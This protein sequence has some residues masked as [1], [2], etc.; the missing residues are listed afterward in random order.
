VEDAQ[1]VTEDKVKELADAKRK[2]SVSDEGSATPIQASEDG[3]NA[4][5]AA[6]KDSEVT[7]ELTDTSSG[8]QAE[9]TTVTAVIKEVINSGTGTD[10]KDVSVGADD[11]TVKADVIAGLSKEKLDKLLIAQG[12]PVAI[13]DGTKVDSSKITVKETTIPK[14]E[15]DRKSGV[16]TVTF[17]YDGVDVT[18]DVYVEE[19]DKNPPMVTAHDIIISV[20]EIKEAVKNGT[21][22]GQLVERADAR[23]TAKKGDAGSAEGVDLSNA[24]LEKVSAMTTPGVVSITFGNTAGYDNEDAYQTVKVTVVN[25]YRNQDLTQSDDTKD[26]DLVE[27]GANDFCISLKQATAVTKTPNQTDV[28]DMLKELANTTAVKS[29]Y[30]VATRGISVDTSNIK[31]EKGEYEITFT[32]KGAS[33]TRTVTVK[34]DGVTDSSDSTVLVPGTNLTANNFEVKANSDEINA[35]DFIKLASV[36]AN[37]NT[38]EP[39]TDITVDEISLKTLNSTV[40]AGE[41]KDTKV[42]VKV[43]ANGE[44][45]MVTVTVKGTGLT[46]T[47]KDADTEKD[48]G[49]NTETTDTEEPGVVSKKDIQDALGV[50]AETAAKIQ[51]VA[52][53]YN[54][55]L[56]TLKI[57][58][59]SIAAQT[60][61]KDMKG[62]SFGRLKAR[63]IKCKNKQF[64]L[65]WTKTTGADGYMIYGNRCNS[66]GKKYK[67]KYIKTVSKKTTSMK[68]KKLKKGTYYKYFVRAYKLI[69]GKKVTIATSVTVHAT[70]TGGKGGVAKAVKIKKIG[71]KKINSSKSVKYTLKKGKKAKISAAEVKQTTKKIYHHRNICYESSDKSVATVDKKGKITAKGKGKCKIW[72]YAQNG[73]YTT[74]NL[75]VK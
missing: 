55:S 32:Y 50:S 21:L 63:A 70:T 24:D 74:I 73:V 8:D 28:W 19:E 20:D 52:K 49:K 11:I 65:K 64:T 59:E 37:K 68:I 13:V 38:G 39:V 31:A 18:V 35:A 10:G 7:I 54:V 5:K 61:D 47:G 2:D 22:K 30:N 58:D 43:Y 69:D 51:D 60:N 36:T 67:Y 34:D 44:T 62:T 56:D 23:Y 57:T 3:V 40:A 53:K 42:K 72:V 71:K 46:D 14:N 27:I 17:D 75:T 9:S 41:A 16:Y 29:G 66:H 12:N 25:D 1:K 45:A 26:V 33:V 48:T 6:T 15:D 4:L